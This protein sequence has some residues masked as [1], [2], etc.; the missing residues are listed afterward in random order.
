MEVG[1]S[2]QL[3]DNVIS[4]Q[5]SYRINRSNT[6]RLWLAS[7]NL[8]LFKKKHA[9]D[10]SAIFFRRGAQACIRSSITQ[11]TAVDRQTGYG[12]TVK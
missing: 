5:V 8:I 3:I 11:N 1:F 12:W 10:R 7:T 4:E 6:R 9:F 2:Y